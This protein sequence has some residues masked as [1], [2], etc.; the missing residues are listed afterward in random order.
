MFDC[1]IF[2]TEK[3]H[4][5]ST[6]FYS[7][8]LI[9]SGNNLE[10]LYKGTNGKGLTLQYSLASAYGEFMERLQ[11]DYIFIDNIFHSNIFYSNS[12]ISSNLTDILLKK[13]L[14]LDF[15]Y[16]PNEKHMAFSNLPEDLRNILH[17]IAKYNRCVG[18]FISVY[19]HKQIFVPFF[20][21]K[22]KAKKFLPIQLF[23][24]KT[25]SNGMCAGNTPKEALIQGLCEILER[26]AIKRIFQEAP[27]LPSIPIELFHHTEIYDLI[28]KL[29]QDNHIAVYIKDCS[30]GLDIPIIG[31]LIIDYTT[32]A[33][34]FN[35]GAAMSPDIA[36][37]RCFTE[38][39]QGDQYLQM[40][41]KIDVLHSLNANSPDDIKNREMLSF[42]TKGKGKLPNSIFIKGKDID[43]LNWE[44]GQNDEKDFNFL[45]NAILS[46]GYDIYIRDVSFLG[47]PS[48]Y[49]Y[50]PGMSEV[51]YPF[52]ENLY[53]N[54]H[55][56]FFNVKL[57][58]DL[59]NKSIKEYKEIISFLENEK[60]D[61]IRLFPYNIS[62]DNTYN[63]M[64]LLS[65]L[66]YRISDYRKASKY[67]SEFIDS[68]DSDVSNVSYFC[69]ARDFFYYRSLNID[70]EEIIEYLNVFYPIEIVQEVIIDLI[71][72][73]KIFDYQNLSKC[74]DCHNCTIK[75]ECKL[76]DVLRIKKKMQDKQSCNIIEQSDLQKLL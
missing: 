25:G 76:I 58:Y 22:E 4:K 50:I 70:K 8:R 11:N 27:V 17:S 26:Y 16:D 67:L 47:F 7:C 30:F 29:Q 64:Y 9:V 1:D 10:E 12:G 20:S 3:Y 61:N 71:D 49:I 55:T 48:F 31:V 15:R 19:N 46:L 51:M 2:L 28:T 39:Y 41:N 56:M 34:V 54:Y 38:I 23:L 33:Y 75:T 57:L 74:F 40:L 59:K 13:N 43:T 73:K 72:E 45:I 68:L 5:V 62:I 63:R 18:K 65:L 52:D 24:E 14:L 66:C 35:V 37:Q 32:N 60:I 21:V 69:C 6:N 44:L 42:I 36:L 53:D